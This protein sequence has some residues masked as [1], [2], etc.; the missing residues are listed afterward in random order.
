MTH[1][2]NIVC[3][4]PTPGA[5]KW[6]IIGL[7]PVLAT[8]ARAEERYE[9]GDELTK[10][11]A[12][13]LQVVVKGW[14]VQVRDMAKDSAAQTIQEREKFDSLSVAQRK[15]IAQQLLQMMRARDSAAMEA[16]TGFEKFRSLLRAPAEELA[17]DRSWN[18]TIVL[19]DNSKGS[20][21]KPEAFDG[22]IQKYG[23]DFTQAQE[24]SQ[25]QMI[26]FY[27]RE[28]GSMAGLI[29]RGGVDGAFSLGSMYL[30]SSIDQTKNCRAASDKTITDVVSDASKG[31][32]EEE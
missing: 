9:F 27:R 31:G 11:E 17:E 7:L 20:M 1:S 29:T 18:F 15:C 4:K 22:E 8:L 3:A 12:Q 26:G 25:G 16:V 32:G 14:T 19:V 6:A 5:W 13:A 10:E 28:K 2:I 30:I 23:S 21:S 24:K